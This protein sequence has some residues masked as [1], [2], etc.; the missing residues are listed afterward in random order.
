ML[1]PDEKTSDIN[2]DIGAITPHKDIRQF[3]ASNNILQLNNSQTKN[4][5]KIVSYFQN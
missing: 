5:D 3:E 1:T 4:V 2:E